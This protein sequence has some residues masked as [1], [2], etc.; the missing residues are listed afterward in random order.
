MSSDYLHTRVCDAFL[1]S[2]ELPLHIAAIWESAETLQI[3][4]DYGADV[5]AVDKVSQ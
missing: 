3:L 2:G 5:N 4:I 1:Q